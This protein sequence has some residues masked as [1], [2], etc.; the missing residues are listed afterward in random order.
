MPKSRAFTIAHSRGIVLALAFLI[1][2]LLGLSG[3]NSG[4]GGDGGDP[5]VSSLEVKGLTHVRL[6][7]L[8]G[9]VTLSW[10]KVHRD[11]VLGYAI[12]RDAEG[13]LSLSDI[14][15]NAKRLVDTQYVDTLPEEGF[16]WG[17]GRRKFEYRVKILNKEGRYGPVGDF[18]PVEVPSRGWVTTD[19][20]LSVLGEKVGRGSIGD[21]LKVIATYANPTRENVSLTWFKNGASTGTAKTGLG[22]SGSDTLTLS[23]PNASRPIVAVKIQDK[24]GT[25]WTA[26]TELNIV[27]DSPVALAGVDTNVTRGDS[28]T[29][30][31]RASNEFG[32][33]VKWEWDVGLKGDFIE[34]QDGRLRIGIPNT[35]GGQIDCALRVTDDDGLTGLDDKRINIRPGRLVASMKQARSAPQAGVVGGKIYVLGGG[36]FEQARSME[37][38]DP[39]ANIWTS[40]TTLPSQR[41]KFRMRA[42]GGKLYVV[43]GKGG[44]LVYER[45]VEAYDPVADTWK[46]CAPV[47]ENHVNFDLAVVEDTLVLIKHTYSGPSRMWTA[48]KYLPAEDRWE[49]G[50]PADGVARGR[51]AVIGNR[52]YSVVNNNNW[53]AIWFDE[54]ELNKDRIQTGGHLDRRVSGV[55]VAFGGKIFLIGKDAVSESNPYFVAGNGAEVNTWE[56]STNKWAQKDGLLVPRVD[57][58]VCEVGGRLY[59]IGGSVPVTKQELSSVEEYIPY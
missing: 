9:L 17:L 16:S 42:A 24:G 33:I 6:D 38:Y 2:S 52:I 35:P 13:A 31:G 36:G 5:P 10:N 43:G 41:E 4:G 32:R 53:L 49:T 40:V 12:F 29:L 57:P 1:S 44:S 8:D 20:G 14:P 37:R 28:I 19:V 11:D 51:I 48:A 58:A 39:E 3:C 47:P 26:S 30:V 15:V 56:P 23:F 22:K 45:M 46:A 34:T 50:G 7:T 25:V 18:L 27:M 55:M 54:H 21:T 59:V